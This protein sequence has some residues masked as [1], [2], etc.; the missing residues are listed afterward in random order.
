MKMVYYMVLQ[1]LLATMVIRKKGMYIFFEKKLARGHGVNSTFFIL[2]FYRCYKSGRLDG[3]AKYY[4]T[5]GAV[6]SRIYE[7]GILQGNYKENK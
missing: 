4:Y 1:H 5:S 3:T 6:E 7:N 2:V